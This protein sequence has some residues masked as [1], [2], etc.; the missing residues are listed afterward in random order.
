MPQNVQRADQIVGPLTWRQLLILGAGGGA[1]YAIYVSLAKTYHIE[2]WLPPVAIIGILT[3]AL[4]FIKVHGL[5]FEIYLLALIEY[6][7]LPKKRVWKKGQAEPFISFAQRKVKET[8]A[9]VKTRTK[10]KKSFKELAQILDTHDGAED[11]AIQEAAQAKIE[12]KKEL[13]KLISHKKQ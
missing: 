6:H 11:P 1:C 13:S 4:A 8:K 10:T 5:K 12:K 2:V 3:A 7:M 9:P